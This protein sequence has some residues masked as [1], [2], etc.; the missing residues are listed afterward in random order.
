MG[1]KQ[2]RAKRARQQFTDEFKAGAVRL[3]IDEGKTVAQVARELDPTPS[4]FSGWDRPDA[5]SR[6]GSLTRAPPS[7]TSK[8]CT[9]SPGP[10]QMVVFVATGVVHAL[11]LVT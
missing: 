7:R 9:I 8:R 10:P 6:V 2:D 4:A 3:V 5:P 1:A 11:E